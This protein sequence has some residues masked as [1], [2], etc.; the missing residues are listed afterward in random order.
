MEPQTASLRDEPEYALKRSLLSRYN[1]NMSVTEAV[2]RS[3]PITLFFAAVREAD[4]VFVGSGS[5]G[6]LSGS[7]VGQRKILCR[8]ES[9]STHHHP[10]K[11]TPRRSGR[12]LKTSSTKAGRS[13]RPWTTAIAWRAAT[14]IAPYTSTHSVWAQPSLISTTNPSA[15]LRPPGEPV[16]KSISI[17][18]IRTPPDNRAPD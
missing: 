18:T 16:P 8:A 13:S 9:P 2:R 15:T 3:M 10:Q 7:S 14:G 17:S 12:R 5:V 4:E 11:P 1:P 6:K